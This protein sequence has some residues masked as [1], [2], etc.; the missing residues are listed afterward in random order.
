MPAS[1]AMESDRFN[2]ME[3]RLRHIEEDVAIIKSNYSTR[4]DVANL[5][6]DMHSLARQ[7]IMWSVGTILTGMA[8]VFAIL[9]WLSP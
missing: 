6:A 8:L 2:N 7:Q 1:T 4:E 9:K 5:R 3:Q